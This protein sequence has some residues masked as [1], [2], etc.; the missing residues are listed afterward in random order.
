MTKNEGK[1]CFYVLAFRN[2]LSW[3]KN[4]ICMK[5]IKQERMVSTRWT[6]ASFPPVALK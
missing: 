1:L 4:M 6:P 2:T 3:H 5:I